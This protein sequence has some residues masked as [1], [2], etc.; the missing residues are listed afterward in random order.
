VLATSAL[1]P[2][3]V[4]AVPYRSGDHLLA[5]GMRLL[6]RGVRVAEISRDP[7][8]LVAA[9]ASGCRTFLIND[10]LLPAIS[11][12]RILQLAPYVK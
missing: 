7:L 4:L 11:G 8:Q 3:E 10:R 6:S 1:T 2:L 5:Q 9:L 12:L